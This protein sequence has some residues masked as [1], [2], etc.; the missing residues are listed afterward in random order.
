MDHNGQTLPSIVKKNVINVL[1]GRCW[2]QCFFPGL[3]MAEPRCCSFFT[4]F[5]IYVS[6]VAN[7]KKITYDYIGSKVL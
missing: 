6:A 1:L 5:F 7:L 4:S 3:R 2:N